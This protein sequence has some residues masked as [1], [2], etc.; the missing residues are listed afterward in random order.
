MVLKIGSLE[1]QNA[2]TMLGHYVWLSKIIPEIITTC[3][4]L[5]EWLG[6]RNHWYFIYI[7]CVHFAIPVISFIFLI[8][9]IIIYSFGFVS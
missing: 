8:I 5:F 9:M 7:S 4:M 1:K 3:L 6:M 2:F